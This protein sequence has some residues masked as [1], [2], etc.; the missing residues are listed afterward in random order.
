MTSYYKQQLAIHKHVIYILNLACHTY[1]IFKYVIVY[2]TVPNANNDIAAVMVFQY[3]FLL[4]RGSGRLVLTDVDILNDFDDRLSPKLCRCLTSCKQCCSEKARET[5][6]AKRGKHF[7][8]KLQYSCDTCHCF[9]SS[10]VF[11]SSLLV[12]MYNYLH[13]YIIANYPQW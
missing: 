3:L 6:M 4:G 1:N 2:L 13:D 5:S 7:V 10:Y 12:S 11:C 8:L 9:I